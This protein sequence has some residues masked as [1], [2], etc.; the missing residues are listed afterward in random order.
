MKHRGDM[1][2][3][4]YVRFL[5]NYLGPFVE[6][7]Y[8]RIGT[9]D[10]SASRPTQIRAALRS[11]LEGAVE[12]SVLLGRLL[13]EEGGGSQD[14]YEVLRIERSFTHEGAEGIG[15]FAQRF[16]RAWPQVNCVEI[17][18]KLYALANVD[19]PVG[20]EGLGNVSGRVFLREL[21]AIL[22]D[23]LAKAGMSRSFSDMRQIPA[24]RAQAD[25]A[26]AQGDETDP[27]FWLYRFNDYA[28]GWLAKHGCGSVQPEYICHPAIVELARYDE[29]HGSELLRTLA[30]FMESRYNATLAAQSLY[31][32][33]ST[34]INRLERITELTQIDLDDLDER[35]YLGLS[36]KLM[37]C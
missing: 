4:R 2:S 37:G 22:R 10:P 9:L 23:N 12:G 3:A 21:P 19:A 13:A 15:Y 28:L 20:V 8:E 16:E 29:V 26:L 35:I 32:A 14:R 5:L 30:A 25:A 7:M 17:D 6:D 18:G 24:A 27:A 34:L 33:R 31:V 36:L 11:A 1:M